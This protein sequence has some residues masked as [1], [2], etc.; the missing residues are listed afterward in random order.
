MVIENR[1]DGG[2]VRITDVEAILR[3]AH[4]LRSRAIADSFGALFGRRKSR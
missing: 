4:E 1:T 2:P 3:H